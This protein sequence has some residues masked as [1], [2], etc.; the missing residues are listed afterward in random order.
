MNELLAVLVFVRGSFG[1]FSPNTQDCRCNDRPNQQCKYEGKWICRQWGD[2]NPA[3][4]CR[5]R[6]VPKLRKSPGNRRTKD[7]RTNDPDW[8]CCGNRVFYVPDRCRAFVYAFFGEQQSAISS[9]RD[10]HM[11][12]SIVE[13]HFAIMDDLF[14]TRDFLLN[15]CPSSSR[16]GLMTRGRYH[17]ELKNN[18]RKSKRTIE[19][20]YESACNISELINY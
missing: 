6:T 7:R 8:I 1:R 20:I 13:K 17:R 10:N 3:V 5:Y 18:Q 9:H 19:T 4:W 14:L 11:A 16:F 2:E 15:S 12:G